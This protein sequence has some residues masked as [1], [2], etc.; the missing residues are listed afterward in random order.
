MVPITTRLGWCQ[1]KNKHNRAGFH[2]VVPS[3]TSGGYVWTDKFFEEYHRRRAVIF[4][5]SDDAL[6]LLTGYPRQ[7]FSQHICHEGGPD[8]SLTTSAGDGDSGPT[9]LGMANPPPEA[10]FI[11]TGSS[12][13]QTPKPVG[14]KYQL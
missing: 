1:S 2:W 6:S 9:I 4:G 11:K 5:T 13:E 8:Y 3:T 12:S 7:Q 10:R 14:R